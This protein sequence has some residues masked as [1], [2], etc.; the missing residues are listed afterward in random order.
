MILPSPKDALHRGQMYRVLTAIADSSFLSRS[1]IFKGGTCAAMQG[2]LDRFSVDLDFDLAP[3]ISKD[4]VKKNLGGVFERLGLTVKSESIHAVQYVLK[5]TSFKGYRNTLNID[6]VSHTLDY[7]VYTPIYLTDIDRYFI[8]QTIETMF[9]H[10]LVALM[11]RYDKHK[12]LAGRDVYDIYYFFVNGYSYNNQVIAKRTGESVLQFFLKLKD[13]VEEKVGLKIIE[14]DI[15][16]LLPYSKFNAIRKTLK[17]EVLG[18]LKDE[19]G[20]LQNENSEIF[21]GKT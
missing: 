19:I 18:I 21:A 8:C 9:A 6:A 7:S 20:R 13:F 14:E 4:E 3:G 2:C 1:L 10:K 17:I 11:D 16:T 15:N 5:Y 12:S